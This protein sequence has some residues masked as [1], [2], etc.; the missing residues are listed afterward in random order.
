[1]SEYNMPLDWDLNEDKSEDGISLSYGVLNEDT[2]VPKNGCYL[3]LDI[4]KSSTGIT[5][6]EDGVRF[7][8]NFELKVD[9]NSPYKEVLLRRDLK[10]K[11]RPYILGKH[12]EAIIIEDVFAGDNPDTTRLLYALNTAI[13]E[14]IVDSELFCKDFVRVNNRE[15]K[16]WL[17]RVDTDHL[18]KGYNDKERVRIYLELLGIK[19][20]GKGY[21]DRLDSC[22]MILGYLLRKDKN[23][24]RNRVNVLRS[25]IDFFY[26]IDKEDIYEKVKNREFCFIKDTRFTLKSIKGYLNSGDA[27]IVYI[28]DSP[29]LLGTLGDSLGL[30][31]ISEGGYF[32]FCIKESKLD[33]FKK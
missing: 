24:K 9:E 27:D 25:D 11:L 10:S 3:G 5:I 19:D 28:S 13:D 12:F 26:E 16:K 20:E 2:L 17:S 32:G 15:W 6:Y 30:G 33:K 21:Q 14:M 31:L 8:Y 7:Q 29:V 23:A 22:G 4:S 18:A 1:M